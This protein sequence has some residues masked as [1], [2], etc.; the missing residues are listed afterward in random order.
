MTERQKDLLTMTIMLAVMIG[1]FS[2]ILFTSKI[3][4]A[5]DILNEYYWSVKDLHAMLLRD[6]FDVRLTAGWSMHINSGY[7]TEGG[8]ISLQFLKYH[9]LI[10][11]LFPPPASVGWFIVLHLFWGGVGTYLYCR[12]IGA[13]RFAAL[14]GGLIFAIATENASLINAGHVLKIATISYAPFAFYLLEKGFQSR[15]VIFFMA[16]GFALAFQFF[17]YHWQI[18]FYTCM[19]MAVYGIIRFFGIASL[20]KKEPPKLWKLLGLNAVLLVFFLTTVSISLMPLANWSKDTNRGVQSGAN[21]GKGGLDRDEAMSWSMPPEELVT[22][23]IPG[24]FGFSRQEGGENPKNISSY[25][26][27]RM[28]MTQTND[29]MGLLPWL[30]VPLPL[31]FR[32][33]KYVWIAFC[34]VVGGILFSLGKYSYIYNLLYDYFPG[35][36]KF[37]VPKMM[38]FVT[39][40]GL[41]VFAARGTDLLLD[42]NVRKTKAFSRYIAGIILLP[43]LLF[44][45]LAL[46]KIVEKHWINIFAEHLAQPTR[47]QQG[48]ELI[49]ERWGT[50]L[51]ETV[52]AAFFATGYAVLFFAFYKKWIAVRIFP[53][54]V[55]FLLLAD[56]G[57]VNSKFMFTVDVPVKSKGKD[58]QVMAFLKR[59]SNQYRVLPLNSDPL[60]YANS[61]IPVMFTSM[62]VQQTRWQD[63]IDNFSFNSAI[64]DMMNIKYLVFS[65]E[66]YQQEK[67]QLAEKFQPV[68]MS[69]DNSEIVLQNISVLP[70]AWL[71]SSALLARDRLQA[72]D[73]IKNP[74]FNPQKMAVVESAPPLP[75]S[76]IGN[77]SLGL[78]GGV[79]VDRYENDIINISAETAANS[80]L[81]LSEKYY[82]GWHATVDGKRVEIFPVNYILRGVYLPPGKHKVEFIFDPLP[83]KI[84]KYLTLGSFGLFAA[85]LIREWLIRKRRI[86]LMTF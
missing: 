29:Y 71:V 17:N 41:G 23:I 77:Q 65:S 14:T 58:T 1:L 86:K 59:D 79:V 68:F 51:T 19:S 39:T 62:P 75:I 20:E 30:L 74:S 42:E 9:N 54:L 83:F 26:W 34:A 78:P 73:I 33:D 76:G 66:Q 25:Y 50:I 35:I 36:N 22:M 64:P 48:I 21:Q 6:L 63:I 3:I 32:R 57:R 13:S 15:R 45:F 4:R 70:K 67:G 7:T 85:M 24:F 11:K 44:L 69:S 56:I 46:L 72:L 28:H 80:L 8:D 12:I 61:S 40:L 82:K 53:F 47:Y 18:A 60:Q 10:Y 43:V 55:L 49:Y 52:I 37:R 31:I 84:G 16:T 2:P 5:P 27:G 81:I 38:M